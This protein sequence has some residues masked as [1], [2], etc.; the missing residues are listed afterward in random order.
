MIKINYLSTR[1]HEVMSERFRFNKHT[2]AKAFILYES[3]LW[4]KADDAL[5]D[6]ETSRFFYSK[7]ELIVADIILLMIAF[8]HHCG[9]QNIENLLRRRIED[10]EEDNKHRQHK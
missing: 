6:K 10:N 1:I 2:S 7:T 4:R 8:L 9:V 3:V 5:K